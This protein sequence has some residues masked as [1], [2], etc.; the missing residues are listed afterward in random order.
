[1]QQ[2]ALIRR[3]ALEAR[4]VPGHGTEIAVVQPGDHVLGLLDAR[5]G[6]VGF[7]A[8]GDS[9]VF[10]SSARVVVLGPAG[11]DEKNV[12]DLDV[13]TLRGRTY[14]YRE[15]GRMSVELILL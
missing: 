11:A 2:P 15:L 12:A 10:F 6:V 14:V 3:P 4:R 13:T 5:P 8:K 9:G 1:M 7:F